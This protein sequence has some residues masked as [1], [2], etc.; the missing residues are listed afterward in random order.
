MKKEL[1]TSETDQTIGFI[2]NALPE[3]QSE[4]VPLKIVIDKGLQPV[5]GNWK[6]PENLTLQSEIP[7]KGVFQVAEITGSF[8][9][10]EGV[11]NVFMNQPVQTEK[12][13]REH[14]NDWFIGRF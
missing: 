13:A 3:N 6:T 12:L 8:V 9:E 14:R 1:A 11:M 7:P 10:G 5:G 4:S 2:I